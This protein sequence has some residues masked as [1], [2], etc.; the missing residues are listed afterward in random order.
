MGTVLNARR[1]RTLAALAFCAQAA[2]ASAAEGPNTAAKKAATDF[3][4]VYVA[5]PAA[6]VPDAAGLAKLEPT[7]TPALHALLVG[8]RKAEDQHFKA[9]KNEEPPLFEG[10]L[11]SSLFEGASE[12]KVGACKGDA[13]RAECAVT[14]TQ[15][16]KGKPVNWTDTA[17]V[18]ATPAG[19]R[20]D[21]I[22][23]GGTWDFGNK[24]RLSDALKNV[25]ARTGTTP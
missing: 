1:V 25:T 24:G 20:L 22:V 23:Y 8:A 21:D 7:I 5:L 15:D 18:I 17:V 10:D 13:K 19:W 9:T 16:P 14:L 3:Y 6:G 4:A 2:F 11:F 12:Y